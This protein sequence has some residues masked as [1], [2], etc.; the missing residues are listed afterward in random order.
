MA[1]TAAVEA[2]APAIGDRLRGEQP[3]RLRSLFAAAVVGAAAAGLTYKLLRSASE[4]DGHDAE[5]D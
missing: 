2:L 4:H 3:S 5:Q 1:T